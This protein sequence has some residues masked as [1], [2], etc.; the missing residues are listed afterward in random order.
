MASGSSAKLRDPHA[1][2]KRASSSASFPTR[3]G[4]LIP[5]PKRR[6]Q[7][8][9]VAREA[10]EHFREWVRH[11][12]ED[13]PGCFLIDAFMA[14]LSLFIVVFNVYTF[15]DGVGYNIPQWTIGESGASWLLRDTRLIVPT[16]TLVPLADLDFSINV[17][18]TIEC[19]YQSASTSSSWCVCACLT[20]CS[21]TVTVTQILRSTL[22]RVR[23]LGLRQS[24]APPR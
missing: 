20:H 16:Y 22:R 18:F 11:N 3:I 21:R 10:G 14:L 15:W 17:V 5:R 13:A 9:F 7:P 8:Y 4:V 24:A 6:R 23:S 19:V 1:P 2:P 12:L